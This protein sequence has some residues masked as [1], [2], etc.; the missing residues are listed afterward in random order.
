MYNI[1]NAYCNPSSSLQSAPATRREM[2]TDLHPSTS[3]AP[4]YYVPLGACICIMSSAF[5][6]SFV[7]SILRESI[8]FNHHSLPNTA[9]RSLGAC[10]YRTRLSEQNRTS[11]KK[12]KQNSNE[13]PRHR[14]RDGGRSARCRQRRIP[15]N[16]RPKIRPR[17][18][19]PTA[20]AKPAA[21]R[22]RNVNRY[23]RG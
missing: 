14:H 19:P 23:G 8:L 16:H 6:S 5:I 15:R 2:R 7:Q 9:P 3:A 11:T 1:L 17:K 18:S 13:N 4:F 10:T 20:T 12:T 22:G 21:A